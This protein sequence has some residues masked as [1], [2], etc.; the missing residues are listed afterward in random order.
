[1]IVIIEP[2]LRIRPAASIAAWKRSQLLLVH[3]AVPK[4]TP[5]ADQATAAGDVNEP[6]QALADSSAHTRDECRKPAIPG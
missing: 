6:D 2:A 1:M 5:E 4:E 3:R